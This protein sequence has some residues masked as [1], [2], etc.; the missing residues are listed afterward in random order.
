MRRVQDWTEDAALHNQHLQLLLLARR[1]PDE[2]CRQ[3]EQDTEQNAGKAAPQR[4]NK[5]KKEETPNT[6]RKVSVKGDEALPAPGTALP[7]PG[8][9]KP[10]A[11][12]HHLTGR[13]RGTCSHGVRGHTGPIWKATS[14]VSWT[15]SN[16]ASPRTP[17]FAV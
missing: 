14:P 2:I 13:G 4:I 3:R 17:G 6:G 1:N 10:L 5:K 16:T 15:M 12:V 9:T 11:F 7:N 8:G